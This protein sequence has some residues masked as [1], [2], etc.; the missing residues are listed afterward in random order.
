MI[1]KAPI[2][3]C[4]FFFAYFH[5][6]LFLFVYFKLRFNYDDVESINLTACHTGVGG[7]IYS[8]KLKRRR[9]EEWGRF[10]EL[11]WGILELGVDCPS[12]CK[13]FLGD[14]DRVADKDGREQE[15]W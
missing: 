13:S 8:H 4:V 5:R 7:M 10:L 3:S 9:F 14:L 2:G 12:I 11:A 15:V 1:S 6:G